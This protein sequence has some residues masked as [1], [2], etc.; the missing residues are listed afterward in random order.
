[1]TRCLLLYNIVEADQVASLFLSCRY[2]F[3]LDM[4]IIITDCIT[5]ILRLGSDLRDTFHILG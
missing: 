5:L 1:M 4:N 3:V 2:G